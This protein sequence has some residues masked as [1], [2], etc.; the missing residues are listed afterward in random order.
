MPK[1]VQEVHS[2]DLIGAKT[3]AKK[4]ETVHMSIDNWKNKQRPIYIMEKIQEEM[5]YRFTQ[6]HGRTPAIM[7]NE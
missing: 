2:T 7:P 1:I 6:K 3:T 4:L 5:K